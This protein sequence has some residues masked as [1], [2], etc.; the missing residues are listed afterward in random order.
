MLGGRPATFADYARLPL[1]RAV[2]DEALRLYPPAWLITRKSL[3]DDALG[4]HHI[5]ES[6]LLILSPWLLHRHP[7]VW[8]DAESFRPERFLSGEADRTAF[9][10]FGA[11]LRQCIGRDFAYVEGVLMLS[12][13]AGQL[14]LR[15][16]GRRRRAGGRAA[17][18]RAPGRRP[19][20]ARHRR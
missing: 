6:S 20:A 9:I 4:G 1:A 16:P 13:I 12:A 14:R 2:F 3:G 8:P 7:A 15:L 10:P 17:G 11:G 5:P 18:D 19:A